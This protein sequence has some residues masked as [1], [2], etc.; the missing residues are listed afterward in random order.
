MANFF[1]T[2]ATALNTSPPTKIKVNLLGGRLRYSFAQFT[3]FVAAA[4][5]DVIYMGRLPRGARM[6]GHLSQVTWNTGAASCTA[7]LGDNV[8]VARHMGA[9]AITAAGN[10]TPQFVTSSN[11]VIGYETTDE[12]RDGTGTPTSTND[13]DLR[14]TLAGANMQASQI[15]ANHIMF[16]QD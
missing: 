2:Q 12:T 1:S 16:V 3:N 9:T 15:I 4:I 10:S 7:N 5:A 8:T 11:G 14:H 13:C 6:L